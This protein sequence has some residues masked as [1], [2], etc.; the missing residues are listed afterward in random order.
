MRS[1]GLGFAGSKRIPSVNI[2]VPGAD[3]NERKPNAVENAFS[4]IKEFNQKLNESERPERVIVL[5]A[6]VIR[7]F[8]LCKTCA[9]FVCCCILTLF[10]IGAAIAIGVWYAVASSYI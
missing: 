10:L 1:N 5:P 8:P 3:E 9:D 2:M 7:T 4:Q 6:Q